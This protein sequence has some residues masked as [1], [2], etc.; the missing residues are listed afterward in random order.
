MP[1]KTTSYWFPAKLFRGSQLSGRMAEGN[2]GDLQSIAYIRYI[3][4]KIVS[5]GLLLIRV[6]EYV[7][8]QTL[9][10]TFQIT[11]F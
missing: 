4:L 1:G 5:I 11:C 3:T 7:S 2:S 10:Y 9:I 6:L 8:W